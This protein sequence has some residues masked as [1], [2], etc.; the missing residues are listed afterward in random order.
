MP[1][2]TFF[3]SPTDVFGIN[4]LTIYEGEWNE[5]TY[6]VSGDILDGVRPFSG[7]CRDGSDTGC[8]N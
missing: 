7:N 1:P 6:C 4:E 5:A 8:S 2:I 3:H